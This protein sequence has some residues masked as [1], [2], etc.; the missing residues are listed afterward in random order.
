M[1]KVIIAFAA[2]ALTLSVAQAQDGKLKK[3]A[4][5][6]EAKAQ[7]AADKADLKANKVA[8]KADKAAGNTYALN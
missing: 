3:K 5:T 7:V 2:L 8:R 4:E 6:T 1:K